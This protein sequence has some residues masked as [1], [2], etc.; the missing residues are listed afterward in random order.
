MQPTSAEHQL[1]IE[2]MLPFDPAQLADRAFTL[3]LRP[4]A[5]PCVWCEA[6]FRPA[7]RRDAA[8]CGVTCR[9]AAHRAR[10]QGGNG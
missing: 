4:P 3:D 5:R 2:A 8:Y 6:E 1:L 10:A 7:R 9:V